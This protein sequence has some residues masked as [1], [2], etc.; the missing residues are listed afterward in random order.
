MVTLSIPSIY[1]Y[2]ITQYY[3]KRVASCWVDMGNSYVLLLL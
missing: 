2:M 1:M 3:A